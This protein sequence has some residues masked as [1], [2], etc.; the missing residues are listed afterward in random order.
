MLRKQQE[1]YYH[2]SSAKHI[3]ILQ[4]VLLRKIFVF[5]GKREMRHQGGADKKTQSHVNCF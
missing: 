4:I 2:L 1:N 3:K 5:K